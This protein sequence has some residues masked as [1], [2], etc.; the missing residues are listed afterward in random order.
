M[1]MPPFIDS[2]KNSSKG[3]RLFRKLRALISVTKVSISDYL[4]QIFQLIHAHWNVDL[5][6]V[7]ELVEE[8][9]RSL[10][11]L[12]KIHV[13]LIIPLILP[14]L[15]SSEETNIQLMLRTIIHIGAKLDEYK[16]LIIPAILRLIDAVEI[17]QTI[18]IQSLYTLKSFCK[19]LNLSDFASPIVH[20]LS[21]LFQEYPT[22]VKMK[23][24]AFYILC[25]L[26]HHLGT[27]FAVFVPLLKRTLSKNQQ[28]QFNFCDLEIYFSRMVNKMLRNQNTEEE[29]E[30]LRS[31]EKEVCGGDGDYFPDER[32]R[33]D[34]TQETEIERERE[35]LIV[36]D[37][38]KK[39]NEEVLRKTFNVQ[40]Q[41]TKDDW[42][43]WM[44]Q[45][46]L[47]LI[48]E[49]PEPA[50]RYCAD[51]AKTY[52]PI[53][54][55]LFNAAF[56]SCWQ[57]LSKPSQNE[58]LK[59]FQTALKA[60]SKMPPET[61]QML[62][63]HVEFLEHTTMRCP[64]S[65]NQ[66]SSLAESCHA[67]A[68]ALHYREL[69]F[70]SHHTDDSTEALISL[71]TR[72]HLPHAAEGILRSMGIISY[73][74]ELKYVSWYEKLH[75]WSE[76]LHV[77]ET[78]QEDDK[79]RRCLKPEERLELILGQIR[80]LHAMGEWERLLK[81]T[82]ALWK[83][84][85][86]SNPG[87][88][89]KI[90]PMGAIAAWNLMDWNRMNT[91]INFISEDT[92][93]GAF[94]RAIYALQLEKYDEVK[95]GIDK[96][97]DLLDEELTALFA[98]SYM[99]AYPAIVRL[100]Q[101][102]EIEEVTEY[103][104]TQDAQRRQKIKVIWSKRL[105]GCQKNLRTW[106]YI[107]A[108]RRMALSPQE[109]VEEWLKYANIAR[110]S[111]N[112]LVSHKTL[113]MLL[114]K[115]P[116]MEP[117]AP[118]P[119]TH[120]VVTYAYIKQLWAANSKNHALQFLLGFLNLLQRNPSHDSK[121]VMKIHLKLGE[122]QYQLHEKN[123]NEETIPLILNCFSKAKEKKNAGY[124]VWQSWAQIN[125][126]LIQHFDKTLRRKTQKYT[127]EE[128]T[129]KLFL[130]LLSYVVSSVRAF[131]TT[132]HLT[133]KPELKDVLRLLRLLFKYGEY[134]EV[135]SEFQQG[136]NIVSIDTWL[137]VIPQIIA[138]M[139]SPIKAVQR[140]IK[141]LLT[142]VGREHP[143][144][145]VYPLSVARQSHSKSR[146]KA[147]QQVLLNLLELKNNESNAQTR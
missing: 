89:R 85:L 44:R 144:A 58:L 66:L 28:N 120:P 54:K 73:H 121:L 109:N 86:F 90:A 40:N 1:I 113:S 132:I 27:S 74:L 15:K 46:S 68:K 52:H 112:L 9:S 8:I 76:A 102:S 129:K 117:L 26:I 110:K 100:Q 64:L 22:N 124:K 36:E 47:T 134:K 122:W 16:H 25:H 43:E 72:L 125:F 99:R 7:L 118:L 41:S 130:N 83:D 78:R 6:E 71:N 23:N 103:K 98:E 13:P 82:K 104:M 91:F 147:A 61:L 75:R 34:I 81:L 17:Q 87:V 14:L 38:K 96:T 143:Q 111:G 84:S 67:Y 135:S 65:V 146:Q 70:N 35:S 30:Q 32:L 107:M 4:D 33:D 3:F 57:A 123:L 136:F 55:D 114:G 142:S 59:N 56:I 10:P 92:V 51:L 95:I 79:Y 37:G 60:G 77:Y 42:I 93:E 145:L 127:K 69:E 24:S 101:L 5:V 133:K 18:R 29:Y 80:C 108:V 19:D 106:Q 141:D 119:V 53:V 49:S 48:T 140:L 115:D 137:E 97:R 12:F 138:R 50:I 62:L 105:M 2:I 21:R 88:R 20:T 128:A 126:Q 31:I 94:Y 116:A 45:C 63:Q 139:D 11:E 131:F 39:I